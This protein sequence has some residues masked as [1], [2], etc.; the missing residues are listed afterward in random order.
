MYMKLYKAIIMHWD[1]FVHLTIRE[2]ILCF[3]DPGQITRAWNHENFVIL[4][5]FTILLGVFLV[6][7]FCNFTIKGHITQK[8]V[9]IRPCI[10][11]LQ[12]SIKTAN[13]HEFKPVSSLITNWSTDKSPCNQ[14]YIHCTMHL[15]TKLF[16]I[17]SN[18]TMQNEK[19]VLSA[20]I[21]DNI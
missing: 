4:L 8:I 11:K 9:C 17:L 13:S 12:K 3:S 16:Q 21:N 1:I 18:S 19:K 2:K 7:F 14:T 20:W 5:I 6:C 15:W 10:V